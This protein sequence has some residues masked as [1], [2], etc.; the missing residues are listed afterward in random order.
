M[1]RGISGVPTRYHQQD[2]SADHLITSS[3]NPHDNPDKSSHNNNG[4][5]A[6]A[7]HQQLSSLSH[8]SLQTNSPPLSMNSPVIPTS[9]SPNTDISPNSAPATPPPIGNKPKNKRVLI[10]DDSAMNRK[11]LKRTIAEMADSVDEAGNGRECLEKVKLAMANDNNNDNGNNGKGYEV[12][13]TDYFM[14]EMNGLEAI[15]KLR[16][17]EI[18]YRGII[19]GLTGNA[20]SATKEAFEAAGADVVFTKPFA[21]DQLQAALQSKLFDLFRDEAIL[22]FIV[23]V[24]EAFC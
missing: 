15:G 10:V 6:V 7:A 3:H 11:F 20:D 23:F 22:I 24:I 19:I 5:G 4:T 1:I 9:H 14:P 16:S 8:P 2:V 12:I 17:V 13:I 18:G 21:S